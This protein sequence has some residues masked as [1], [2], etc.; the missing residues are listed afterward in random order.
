MDA[1]LLIEEPAPG[2]MLLTLN[3]PAQRNAIDI[4]LMD[5]L[6]AAFDD[7]SANGHWRAAVMTG[8]APAFCAGLDLKT[9]TAPDAP[10]HFSPR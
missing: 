1:V 8:A 10:R 6:N 2:V 3:R 5:A 4:A 7:L 9:F